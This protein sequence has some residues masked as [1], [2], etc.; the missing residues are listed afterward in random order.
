MKMHTKIGLAMLL[1]V[2]GGWALQQFTD[3]SY[4]TQTVMKAGHEVTLDVLSP[5]SQRA[6]WL[7]PFVMAANMFMS[8]LKMLIVPLVLSSIVTGVSGIS[9]GKEFGRLGVKTLGYYMTTSFLAIV[10]GLLVINLTSPGVGAPLN[11][12][13]PENFAPGEG[14][15]FIDILLRMIPQNVFG[16]LS[17]NGAML[18]II[19]FALLLGYFI[20]HTEEPHGSR[21]RGLFESFFEVMMKL[22]TGV[23]KLIPYGVFA[24]VIKVVGETGFETFKPLLYYMGIVAFALLFHACVVL[25]L[26]LKFVG[27]IS[28]IAWFRAM[29]PALMTAFSTSSSSITL[30]VTMETA[31]HNGKVSNKHTSFVLPLGATVN[32]DGTA[33]YECVGVIFLS[34]YYASTG[35]FDLTLSKQIFIV[36]TALFASIGAAGIPSAGL[37]MMTAILSALGLPIEGAML[38]LAIDRPLDM[39]RTVVNVWSDSCGAALIAKSEGDAILGER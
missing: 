25:P 26:L 19:V 28:P 39:L 27:G 36:I 7:A 9:G 4:V 23:L 15:S 21:I 22:A 5:D 32:M 37:I 3:A 11:L 14:S 29:S 33:L 17:D 35:D 10:T 20:G 30:P 8:L 18:Q 13:I 31:E 24:L 16:A 1:G 34:Q 38:L 12:A 6:Q 2:V